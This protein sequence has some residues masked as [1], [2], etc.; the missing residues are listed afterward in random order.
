MLLCYD[1]PPDKTYDARFGIKI[2]DKN[3]LDNSAVPITVTCD[4]CN[5]SIVV[6]FGEDYDGFSHVAQDEAEQ[7]RLEHE[8]TMNMVKSTVT[9][10]KRS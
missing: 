5:W 8:E 10:L 4:T 2:I 1:C 9:S 6:P 7:H 3:G